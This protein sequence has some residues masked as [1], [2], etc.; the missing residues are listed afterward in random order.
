MLTAFIHLFSIPF[1]AI[2]AVLTY[3]NWKKDKFH[4]KMT[5]LLLLFF[6]FFTAYQLSLSLP[7]LMS[8]GNLRIAGWG[9]NLAIAF[10]FLAINPMIELEMVFTRTGE[11]RKKIIKNIF[12]LL[13]LAIVGWQL[14]KFQLPIASESGFIFWNAN[15]IGAWL[16]SL[17]TFLISSLIV[18]QIIIRWP[19]G[20]GLAEKTKSFFFCVGAASLGISAL[21]YY[22]SQNIAQSTVSSVAA[23]IGCI[24]VTAAVLFPERTEK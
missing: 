13:G 11:K 10:V 1:I 23:Y 7:Y 3:F 9:Y 19:S 14:Y 24:F 17:A 2:C 16:T 8:G 15:S 4:H 22:T 20:L 6:I 5:R 18:I 21:I 12:I